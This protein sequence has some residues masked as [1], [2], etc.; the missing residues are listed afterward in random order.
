MK[1]S[2]SACGCDVFTCQE[3]LGHYGVS[4]NEYLVISTS[5]EFIGGGILTS[6]E[7]VG[8]WYF[9]VSRKCG[10]VVFL[11]VQKIWGYGILTPPENLGVWYFD[12][13]IK[14]GLMVF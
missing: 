2:I 6:P 4:T 1:L 12:A 11:R 10:S 13:S 5:T 14:S 7:S 3:N 9:H 8:V